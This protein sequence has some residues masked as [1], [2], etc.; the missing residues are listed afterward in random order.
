MSKRDYIEEVLAKQGRLHKQGSRMDLFCRRIHPLVA[1]FR[2]V[3]A[4]D[5]TVTWRNEWLKYGAIGYIA[6][7]EGYF[8]LLFA[9]LI[10]HGPPFVSRIENLRDIRFTAETVVAIHT[11]KISL[12]AYVAHLL[13]MNGISDINSHMSALLNVDYIPFYLQ[14]PLSVFNP[15]PV[16][17]VFPDTIA[18][19]ER[20]FK[21]RHL[22]AHELAT[23]E[24]F[25]VRDIEELIGSAAMFATLTDEIVE[26][27]W[28][29]SV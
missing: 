6:C 20:L 25:P 10:D 14:Q 17:E 8:R 7:I 1:G 29:A 3:R 11:K 5:R 19:V 9:D 23:K 13:P 26:R 2:A 24:R 18:N 15:K 27:F 28:L 16:G 22:H 12:G 4:L 21:L